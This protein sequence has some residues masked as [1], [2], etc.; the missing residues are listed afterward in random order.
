ILLKSTPNSFTPQQFNNPANPE[1]HRKTTAEEIW[2]DT[3]GKVDILVAAI[4]TGGSFTGISGVLKSRKPGF[5]AIAVEPEES[6]VISGKKP[7]PHRIQGIGAGFIPKNL[8]TTLIDEIITV[9]QSEAGNMSRR[10]AKE[11]GILVGISAGANVAA[12]IKVAERA[13]NKDKIIV[14]I[15]CDTGER[16]LSTWLFDDTDI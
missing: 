4:G 10:M 13:E 3:D 9:N 15:G 8:D 11:E 2:S 7:G 6:A 1:I 16:Y 5:R 12:A 14:T